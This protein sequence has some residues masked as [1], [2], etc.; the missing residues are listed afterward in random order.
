ME[1]NSPQNNAFWDK[2]IE[3][4]FQ[5]DDETINKKIVVPTL[6]IVKIMIHRNYKKK[7]ET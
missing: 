4:I 6:C 5:S 1:K 7:K 2:D 3:I